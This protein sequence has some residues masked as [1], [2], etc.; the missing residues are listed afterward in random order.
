[1]KPLLIFIIK[2]IATIFAFI[3][4]FF[5]VLAASFVWETAESWKWK[6]L[7]IKIWKDKDIFE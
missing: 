6:S 4:D 1:M 3:S 7:I 5:T 2:C